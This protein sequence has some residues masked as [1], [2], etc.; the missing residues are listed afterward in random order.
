MFQTIY[1]NLAVSDSGA[2][3]Y[4]C[5]IIVIIDESLRIVWEL[6]KRIVWE[7]KGENNS[8]FSFHANS[9]FNFIKVTYIS[10]RLAQPA[11]LWR[12][13]SCRGHLISLSS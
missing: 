10:R 6:K 3:L 5:V 1:L 8:N 7:C 4:Q 13:K 2:L 9:F 11:Y 12:L